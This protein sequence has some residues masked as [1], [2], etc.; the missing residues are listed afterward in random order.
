MVPRHLPLDH[1][2][3]MDWLTWSIVGSVVVA[4]LSVKRLNLVAV[5]KAHEC[6]KAGAIVIDVREEQEFKQDHIP[7]AINVPLNRLRDEISRHAAGQE[8]TIL[9]H[10]LSGTRSGIGKVMLRK[11]GYPNSFNL[12][13][14]GR[15]RKIMTAQSGKP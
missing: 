3:L 2:S 10:C 14:L 8:K 12:G 7:G 6:L 4:Y 1:L 13:S 11:M 9:L 5:G 15:A